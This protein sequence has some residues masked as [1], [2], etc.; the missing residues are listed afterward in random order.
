MPPR[1]PNFQNA[2]TFPSF[3]DLPHSTEAPKD[4][5]HYLVATI[6]ENM[7]FSDTAT[8]ICK[9]RTDTSFAL[10]IHIPGPSSFDVKKLKKG[11]AVVVKGAER[12]GVKD[13]KQGFVGALADDINIIPTSLGNLI[14]MS[15]NP[16]IVATTKDRDEEKGF[17]DGCGEE[18]SAKDLARCKG[19]ESA[20]Y[21]GK[22]CQKK[23]WVEGGHK[24]D[25][26]VMKAVSNLDL[27]DRGW[28]TE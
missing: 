2:T 17:C 22:E 18:K 24:T 23:G 9:D 28:G 10:K 19:C 6:H 21:C 12:D 27:G 1:F 7:T 13:G 25:C 8:F 11:M 3:A 14:F 26:K 5:R 16:L 20:R 15:G 4:P